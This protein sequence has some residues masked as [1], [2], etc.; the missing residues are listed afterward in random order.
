MYY[1]RFSLFVVHKM[2]KCFCF[3]C[4][5]VFCAS[6]SCTHVQ[7]VPLVNVIEAVDGEER[8]VTASDTTGHKKDMAYL[9]CLMKPYIDKRTDL[10]VSDG[11]YAGLPKIIE[12][13]HPGY[14]AV[15]R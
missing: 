12:K 10:V 5:C 14:A 3:F 9:Y 6:Y 15:K 11:T 8:L 1:C 2:I 7:G 13:E 4:C